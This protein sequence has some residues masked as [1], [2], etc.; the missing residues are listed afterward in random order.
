MAHQHNHP[1]G[2]HTSSHSSP[3]PPSTPLSSPP[4]LDPVLDGLGRIN[5]AISGIGQR[6]DGFDHRLGHLEVSTNTR[7]ASQFPPWLHPSAMPPVPAGARD[8]S[9]R[10]HPQEQQGLAITPPLRAAAD[11][12]AT[13]HP[14]T[15]SPT[16]TLRASV[17]SR[18]SVAPPHMA[19]SHSAP[20]TPAESRPL[21]STTDN[22]IVQK[23][24]AMHTNDKIQFRRV[25]EHLGTS[26]RDFFDFLDGAPRP[27]TT[28]MLAPPPS[29]LNQSI[30]PPL[31][32]YMRHQPPPPPPTIH[33]N[34]PPATPHHPT[35]SL[36]PAAPP[37]PPAPLFPTISSMPPPSAPA[38]AT[39]SY[40][41]HLACKPEQLGEFK[42]DP[43]KLEGFISRVVDIHRSDPTAEWE[44]A[45]V[46]TLT[47]VMK[48]DA[49]IWH[50]SLTAGEAA[51][52]NTVKGWVQALRKAFP[53]NAA[54]L[55]RKARELRWDPDTQYANG[56]YHSKLRLLRQAYGY[57]QKESVLVSDIKDGLPPD[58]KSLLRLPRD[59]PTLQQLLEELNEWEPTWK[60]LNSR[61]T[62]STATP[63][64]PQPAAAAKLV[65]ADQSMVRSASTPVLPRV[66]QAPT[67]NR[68]LSLAATYDPSRITPASGGRPRTYRRPDKDTVLTLDRPCMHCGGDHFNFEHHHLPQVRVLEALGD[69]A[70]PEDAVDPDSH[71]S[72]DG[73]DF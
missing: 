72:A 56:Y 47:L 36:P 40:T 17:P 7:V 50:E 48:D 46:R 22:P 64:R 3:P 71:T 70:Y 51:Q 15:A 25:L 20:V 27:S 66:P 53:V 60:Q 19:Q 26:T 43:E 63:A 18:S 10:L 29:L 24:R 9:S 28:P 12:P 30:P 4:P 35:V 16:P 45:I 69:E 57:D 21:S 68:P 37:L 11:R 5:A 42:G 14:S 34:T 38:A 39:S 23:Y 65:T 32:A 2:P 67:N 1:H 54:E 41:R 55:R 73:S 61:T 52:L 62:T 44:A 8:P 31:S 58:M 13:S 49:A 6:L 33:L 59:G